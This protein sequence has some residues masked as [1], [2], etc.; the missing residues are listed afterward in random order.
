MRILVIEDEHRIANT[1]KKGLEQERFAVDIAY[2]GLE[3]YDLAISEEYD[4]IIMDRMLP[5]KDGIELCRDLRKEHVNT[6]I[7]ML[8]AKGQLN[9]KV[10]GLDAG[11][12]DYL[13]KPFAFEELLARIRALIRRPRESISSI[14]IVK[15]LKLDTK[16]FVVER[17]GSPIQLSNKEF[18]LLEYLMRHPNTIIT[19]DQIINHVWNYD[20]DV[21]PNTVEVYIK[22]IRNKID[23]PFPSLEP[24]IHTVRGFGYKLEK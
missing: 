14:L 9:D 16:K 21:L 12:D 19:K 11:A 15:D 22:N 24:L 2:T 7:I 17:L 8:T 18:A 10:E 4:V 5:E 13:T 6:S 1:I 23:S 20:A 3:G